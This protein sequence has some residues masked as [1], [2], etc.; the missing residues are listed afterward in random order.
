VGVTVVTASTTWTGWASSL[1]QKENDSYR[2]LLKR[3]KSLS[4]TQDAAGVVE[5]AESVE[6]A[7][8]VEPIE[9]VEL[10]E[11]VEAVELVEVVE[12][13]ESEDTRR[14]STCCCGPGNPETR[15]ALAMSAVNQKEVMMHNVLVETNGRT[16]VLL[17]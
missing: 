8:V 1:R 2:L 9:L 13:C 10:V 6:L 15:E 14:G 16:V 17:I 4:G 7:E 3:L 11:L 5:L 12:L